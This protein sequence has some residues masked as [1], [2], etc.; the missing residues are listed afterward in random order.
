MTGAQALI[1][2]LKREQVTHIFGY[3]GATICPA[4]DA[5]AQA[6]GIGYTL[7]RTEQNAGHMASG[8]A[9]VSGK[10]GVCMVTS[11]PGATNLITGIATAYM[12][13][14]PM[15]AITGQVPSHL[16]G[17]D[18]FQEVDI[19]GAVAP[20]SKHSYLVKDPDDIPRVV[21][22]AFHIAS[23][24][25]P[26]PVLIDIPIDVQ[27]RELKE[28]SYPQEVNIRGYKPSVRGNELQ[29]KRVAEAIG[30]S[31]QPLI[32]AGGGVWLAG[33]REE[34]LE[35]A[36]RCSIPVVKT[37]MGISLMPTGHPLNLGMVGAHGNYCANKA[38]AKSDLLIMVG[39]R[40]ADRA[41]I[42]PDEIQ[43]RMATIHIDVDPAE[44]GKN[45]QAA[46]PLVGDVKVILRQLLDRDI[47]RPDSRCWLDSLGNYRRAELSRKFPRRE[48]S[49]FPGTLLRRLGEKLEDDAAVCVD[50]GQNQIF[51][52]KY[53]PQKNGRLLTSG[54]LGTM[55]YA[56]PAAVG[57]KAAQPE[58]QTVVV[59]GDGSFQ[60]S[61]NELAA[62]AAAGLDIK[63]VLFQN[64]VLGL[65]HQIQSASPYHGPFGVALDGSP[66]FEKIASAYGIPSVLLSDEDDMDRALDEFLNCPG[67]CV[68]ICRVHPDVST[69]D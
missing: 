67:S 14:I 64:G 1:E 30:Q 68:L 41:I 4:A 44:I 18:I 20:F 19:T 2:S 62:V 11:G 52:C 43:R 40:A 16:L 51:T 5:L 6:E 24:G 46:I 50:V 56:L 36:Q 37:M 35:L 23:T 22:E 28:F 55:G 66:D 34:L 13:S 17:R 15:V 21:K 65:V 27:N 29:I 42:E 32:C 61:M 31:R 8:Y 7:V 69:N 38:L 49:V 48:G 45:M 59:C 54:G 10:A 3:A 25:R 26:G 60:M 39:T 58:R 57:V 63:I 53:L 12:D 47:A 9:R 33:A